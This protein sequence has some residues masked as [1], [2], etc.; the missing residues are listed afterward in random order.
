MIH[1]REF[2]RLACHINVLYSLALHN[3]RASFIR[4]S[5]CELHSRHQGL[6]VDLQWALA[7]CLWVFFPS[8]ENCLL[9]SA[10]SRHWNCVLPTS[11]SRHPSVD[12]IA[13]MQIEHLSLY[14]LSLLTLCLSKKSLDETVPRF[15]VPLELMNSIPWLLTSSYTTM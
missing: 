6:H 15:R 11:N 9:A 10:A 13:C 3:S 1:Y 14:L 7:S 5:W 2:K 8:A 4:F 12:S